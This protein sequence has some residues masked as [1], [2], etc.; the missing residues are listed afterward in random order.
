[1]DPNDGKE[2]GE[3]FRER[4]LDHESIP[5]PDA[6]GK[7][8][9]RL[10]QSSEP[11]DKPSIFSGKFF[12]GFFTGILLTLTIGALV[13]L[14]M[15]EESGDSKN[16]LALSEIQSSQK[17]LFAPSKIEDPL[18]EKPILPE[19]EAF[20]S[21]SI[22]ERQDASLEQHSPNVEENRLGIPK[23]EPY[24]S[25][26][27]P[28]TLGRIGTSQNGHS[29]LQKGGQIFITDDQKNNRM[30]DWIT[31]EFGD[32]LPEV[33]SIPRTKERSILT[34]SAISLEETIQ[35]I[36]QNL[37]PFQ[38]THLGPLN[39]RPNERVL[40]NQNVSNQ[41]DASSQA[42][43]SSPLVQKHISSF[44]PVKLASHNGKPTPTFG[45][46]SEKRKE[47]TLTSPATKD[48][49]S[50]L[51]QEELEGIDERTKKTKLALSP[52]K[53]WLSQKQTTSE[54]SWGE[55]DKSHLTA[56]TLPVG[57][58]QGDEI[59]SLGKGAEELV[60]SEMNKRIANTE[61][62][63]DSLKAKGPDSVQM[64]I[65][66]KTPETE[67]NK[68]TNFGMKTLNTLNQIPNSKWTLGIFFSPE[69][70]FRSL[71]GTDNYTSSV[72]E[73]NQTEKPKISFS[74]GINLQYK[75]TNKVIVGTGIWYMGVGEKGK[76]YNDS[77]KTNPQ[78]YTNSYHYVG[79]PLM[80]GYQLGNRRFNATVYTGIV[81]NRLVSVKSNYKEK[82]FYTVQTPQLV[83]DTTGED[84][85]N[86][87]GQNDDSTATQVQYISTKVPV[88]GPH[89]NNWNLVYV[90]YFELNYQLY[91]RL[92]IHVGPTFKYFLTS[93]YTKDETQ[94]SKPYSIGLQVGIKYNF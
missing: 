47:G 51:S 27:L 9:S 29:S 18:R 22:I 56:A 73:R 5:H 67:N 43:T 65:V 87:V 16:E 70:S 89:Y 49:P 7:I 21:L 53:K 58:Q 20:D 91:K 48:T 42:M 82:N 12:L 92:S 76:Y 40:E 52:S 37:H 14:F 32:R 41:L 77:T 4:F 66:K 57:S 17:S 68:K 2:I 34:A 84:D 50:Q 39:R 54:N 90:A 23:N 63:P 55:A 62:L 8:L 46:K 60:T 19:R 38:I 45:V 93:I 86:Q 88:E 33:A 75:W 28:D 24:E 11:T 74:S 85:Q 71:T 94:K 81:I 69:S 72:Q 31:Q 1:M 26:L 44:L 64:K 30:M 3:V 79:L 25:P 13:F 15:K 80:I 59:P 78:N 61:K 83:S 35:F 6:F 10:P 36:H